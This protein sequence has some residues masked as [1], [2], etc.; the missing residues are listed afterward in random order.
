[1]DLKPAKRKIYAKTPKR[2]PGTPNGPIAENAIPPIHP[3][4]G[5]EF[6]TFLAA[7]QSQMA[8]EGNNNENLVKP[9]EN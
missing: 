1:M 9:H 4:L 2:H 8:Q 3:L 5:G 7:H 6:A